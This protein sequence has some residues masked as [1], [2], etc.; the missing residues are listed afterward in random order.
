M[1]IKKSHNW[2]FTTWMAGLR[3][4]YDDDVKGEALFFSGGH[5]EIIERLTQSL[6]NHPENYYL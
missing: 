3:H 2:E 4:N 1:G 6:L 5:V